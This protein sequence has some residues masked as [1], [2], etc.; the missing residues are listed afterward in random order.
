MKWLS[1]QIDHAISWIYSYR[2]WGPRCPDYEPTCVV[3]QRWRDHDEIFNDPE[4]A[5]SSAP[6]A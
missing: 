4:D 1:W 5:K 6:G 3:C 2:L